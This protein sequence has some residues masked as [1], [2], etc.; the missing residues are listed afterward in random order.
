MPESVPASAHLE[1]TIVC[2]AVQAEGLGSGVTNAQ[3]AFQYVAEHN[4]G[5]GN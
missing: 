1:M 2:Q 5:T 3:S 4:P